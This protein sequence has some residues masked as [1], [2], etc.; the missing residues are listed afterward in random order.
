MKLEIASANSN[1][2]RDGTIARPWE[3]P[4]RGKFTFAS[5][6]KLRNFSFD[7][8]S[9]EKLQALV[10]ETLNIDPALVERGRSLSRE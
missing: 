5:E 2:L 3:T 1:H 8:L 6:M 7:P 10:V 4:N 9:G